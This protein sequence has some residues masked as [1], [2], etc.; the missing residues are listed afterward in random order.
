MVR[1]WSQLFGAACLMLAAVL[2]ATP[3]TARVSIH[4]RTPQRLSTRRRRNGSWPDHLRW[5]TG[6]RRDLSG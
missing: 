5:L 3:A 6:Q 1:V 4:N 2:I